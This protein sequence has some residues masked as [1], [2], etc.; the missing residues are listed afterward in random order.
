MSRPLTTSTLN[1]VE[2]AGLPV[3]DRL[4]AAGGQIKRAVVQGS[5]AADESTFYVGRLERS[6]VRNPGQAVELASPTLPFLAQVRNNQLVNLSNY[7]TLEA[8]P[9]VERG[10]LTSATVAVNHMFSRELSGYARY[11]HH[12]SES[13][14]LDVNN[15]VDVTGRQIPGLARHN[16]VLG[17]TWATPRRLYLSART[18]YR[19]ARYEDPANVSLL[20]AGWTLDF[21]G[22]WESDDKRWLVGAG[23]LGVGA[24]RN[25]RQARNYLFEARYRF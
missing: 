14:F 13:S 11:V 25:E 7:D 17:G 8:A 18:I 4:V 15:S 19:S 1:N 24:T 22:Y 23:V 3:E 10:E 9:I 12:R 20:K 21:G 2:T 5:Y 6:R 16:V